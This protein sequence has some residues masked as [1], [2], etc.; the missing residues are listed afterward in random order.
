M[1]ISL[2]LSNMPAHV[3]VKQRI[4]RLMNGFNCISLT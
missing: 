1:T 3:K 2:P 4:V